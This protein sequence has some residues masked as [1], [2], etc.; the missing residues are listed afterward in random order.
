M[1]LFL[2][3]TMLQD[4]LHIPPLM[5]NALPFACS[6]WSCVQNT[7]RWSISTAVVVRLDTHAHAMSPLLSEN[8]GQ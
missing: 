4:Q 3:P 6:L 1:S 2:R 7:F 5:L 8:L